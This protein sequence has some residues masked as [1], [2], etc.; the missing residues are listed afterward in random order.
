MP[1]LEMLEGVRDVP[2]EE[3]NSLVGDGSPFLEWDWLASLEEAGRVLPDSDRQIATTAIHHRLELVSGN[4]RH[5][6]RV[7]G[8]TVNPVLVR[9]R[10]SS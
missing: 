3:W 8:L 10:Q 2:R 4:L 9:A 7:P 5:F 6:E 1:T